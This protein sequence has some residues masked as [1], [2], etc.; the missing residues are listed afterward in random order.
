M[1]DA[2]TDEFVTFGAFLR[3][4][5]RRAHLTQHEL[6]AA[7]GYS[8]AYI[9]RLEGDTRLPDPDMVRSLFTD[10]LVVYASNE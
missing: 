1:S 2:S 5:R 3:H 4:L 9:T 10:A 6:G 8:A 7:V